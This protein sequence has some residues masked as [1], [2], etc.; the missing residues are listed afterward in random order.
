MSNQLSE[1]LDLTVIDESK[2]YL[3]GV[4]GSNIQPV[5]ANAGLRANETGLLYL[6]G[7]NL[8]NYTTAKCVFD[9]DPIQTTVAVY[10]SDTRIICHSALISSGS[11]VALKVG[12]MLLFL[13]S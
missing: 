10:E 8:F 12:I 2:S 5:N 9:T 7:S 11:S 4:F 3:N 13:I 6:R 1:S